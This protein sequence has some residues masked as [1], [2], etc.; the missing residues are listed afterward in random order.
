[1]AGFRQTPPEALPPQTESVEILEMLDGEAFCLLREA[2]KVIINQYDRAIRGKTYRKIGKK[3]I[4]ARDRH[5]DRRRQ[6]GT[7]AV[8]G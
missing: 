6:S 3:K 4:P 2:A 1:M 8:W 5:A 7:T